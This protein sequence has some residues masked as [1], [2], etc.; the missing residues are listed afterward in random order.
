MRLEKKKLL[1]P[2]TSIILRIEDWISWVNGISPPAPLVHRARHLFARGPS[3]SKQSDGESYCLYEK[4]VDT[5][6][7]FRKVSLA[8][9]TYA[10]ISS[11]HA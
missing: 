2:R 1:R 5:G 10:Y 3:S 8:L 7:E 9:T 6:Q 11:I 4:D